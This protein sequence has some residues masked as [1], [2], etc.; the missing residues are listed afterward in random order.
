MSPSLVWLII[1]SFFAIMLSIIYFTTNKLKPVLRI[2]LPETWEAIIDGRKRK[3]VRLNSNLIIDINPGDLVVLNHRDN[4]KM[5][6]ITKK[7]YYNSFREMLEKEGIHTVFFIRG[8]NSI[9]DAIKY[10]RRRCFYSKNKERKS[11]VC[12]LH[13][14][15]D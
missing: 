15:A 4:T 6:K 3:E 12:V 14:R 8:I 13:F 1:T 7:I 5:V 10:Y 2:K 9:D 11:G